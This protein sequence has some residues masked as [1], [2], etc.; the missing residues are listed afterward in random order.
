MFERA[1]TPKT[2]VV[3]ITNPH[4]PSSKIFS[5]SELEKLSAILEKRPDI[6]VISDDVYFFLP[7]DGR[8]H[9]SFANIGNNWEKTVTVFSAGKLMNCTGWKVGWT[10]GPQDLIKN[11]G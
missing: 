3:M 1:L 7:F 8:Q 5:K 2:K 4:N 6:I 10:V 9:F 11:L